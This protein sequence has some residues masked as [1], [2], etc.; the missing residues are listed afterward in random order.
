VFPVSRVSL[1]EMPINNIIGAYESRNILINRRGALGILSP[2]TLGQF[3]TAT[4][5]PKEKQNI[6]DEFARY[7][8]RQGM[9][10]VIISQAALKWQ[11]MGYPTK[12][13][14]LFEE[15]EDST[16][17]ICD[18]FN[19]PYRLMASEKSNSLGGNDVKIFQQIL[20]QDGIIP[21]AESFY[22]QM[23]TLFKTE[24]LCGIIIEKD[25]SHVAA[26]QADDL[27]TAQARKTR[28]DA[29][30]IEFYNNLITLNR[31]L[32]L[33]GED[34]ITDGAK[35]YRELIEMGWTF[36]KAGLNLSDLQGNNNNNSQTQNS[37]QAQ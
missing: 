12:D 10:Q 36:G 6:Q 19:Y 4:V 30:Q 27:K 13:L 17:R 1:L 35:Y 8:L 25:F 21:D 31:W 24:R 32:E 29:L 28:N 15:I 18:E 34:T 20:Y 3:G 2:E 9:W 22:E 26:L 37:S 14:M 16:M 5:D 23:N 7:G 11:Q 33:N